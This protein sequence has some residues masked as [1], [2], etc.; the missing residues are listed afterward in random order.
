MWHLLNSF[1][2]E[3]SRRKKIN[4]EF[5]NNI[6]QGC[7]VVLYLVSNQSRYS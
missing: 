4:S 5:N 7:S 2:V 6:S 3:G 1:M